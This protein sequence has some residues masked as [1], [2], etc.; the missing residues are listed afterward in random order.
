MIH[1][2]KLILFEQEKQ[3]LL[4]LNLSPQ[5]FEYEIRKLVKKLKI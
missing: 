5:E 2:M 1:Q 4:A 3:N